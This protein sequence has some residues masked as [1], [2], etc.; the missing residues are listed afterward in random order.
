MANFFSGISYRAPLTPDRFPAQVNDDSQA[1]NTGQLNP[2]MLMLLRVEAEK[3]AVEKELTAING[4]IEKL[5]SEYRGASESKKQGLWPRLKETG[6][7]LLNFVHHN[8]ARYIRMEQVMKTDELVFS[9]PVIDELLI[10]KDLSSYI[11]LLPLISQEQKAFMQLVGNNLIAFHSERNEVSLG[12]GKAM[13]RALHKKVSAQSRQKLLNNL[14]EGLNLFA[15]VPFLYGGNGH[16]VME[17][18]RLNGRGLDCIGYAN[19]L[20]NLSSGI[21]HYSPRVGGMTAD[22]MFAKKPEFAAAGIRPKPVINQARMGAGNVDDLMTLMGE[23]GDVFAVQIYTKQKQ[24]FH[25]VVVYN[26]RGTYRISEA[27]I[28]D[29]VVRGETFK[30]WY[31]DACEEYGYLSFNLIDHENIKDFAAGKSKQFMNNLTE[32]VTKIKR[33]DIDG[34]SIIRVEP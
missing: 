12:M 5:I 9:K 31:Q 3:A 18:G 1:E 29:K 32:A 21:G 11:K 17:N 14:K 26:D 7:R 19:I 20:I 27:R 25:V 10:E 13:I 15:G 16:Y 23:Y 28:G 8:A 6:D 34:E 30:A 2:G 4:E 33:P 22:D 24:P